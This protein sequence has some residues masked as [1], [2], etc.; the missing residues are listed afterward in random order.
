MSGSSS[1]PSPTTAP[2]SPGSPARVR[3]RLVCGLLLLAGALLA[4]F[5]LVAWYHFPQHGWLSVQAAA[6]AGAICGVSASA[7]LLITALFPTQQAVQGL[8][9][10]MLIRMGL[11]LGLGLL[12]SETNEP[13]ARANVFG[14]IVINYLLALALETVLAVWVTGA[15]KSSPA[16][17]AVPAGDSALNT[18]SKAS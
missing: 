11:P 18:P 6:V 13:L 12:L 15:N 14:M 10:S 3:I 8:L 7:A 1:T 2:D 5:P 9:L 16:P 17:P 4:L